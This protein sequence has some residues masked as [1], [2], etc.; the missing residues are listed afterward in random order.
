MRRGKTVDDSESMPPVAGRDQ[1]IDAKERH[2]YT[3]VTL[4]RLLKLPGQDSNL[5]PFD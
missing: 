5:R 2:D 4:R 3:V 1:C